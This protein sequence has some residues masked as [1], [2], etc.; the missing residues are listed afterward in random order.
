MTVGPSGLRRAGCCFQSRGEA[1]LNVVK[2]VLWTSKEDRMVEDSVHF[3]KVLS[4]NRAGVWTY[5]HAS[6]PSVAVQRFSDAGA[7]RRE[8]PRQARGMA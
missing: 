3:C 8:S 2:R 1:P 5:D 7:I 4:T 6:A